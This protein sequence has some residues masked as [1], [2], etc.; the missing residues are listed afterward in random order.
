MIVLPGNIFDATSDV[1]MNN[2]GGVGGAVYTYNGKVN[3]TNNLFVGNAAEGIAN[4][5]ALEVQGGAGLVTSF[6]NSFVNNSV[7]FIFIFQPSC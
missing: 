3:I 1:F 6:K 7:R 2:T 5:G 4:G